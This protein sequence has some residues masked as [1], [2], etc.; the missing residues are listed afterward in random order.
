LNPNGQ[1]LQI[2][3]DT[4]TN[5]VYVQNLITVPVNSLEQ[6]VKLI[7]AGLNYRML[8]SQDMNSLSSRSHTILNIYL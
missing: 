5:E 1:K 3:E 6:S 4:E 2:R 7:E 8:G